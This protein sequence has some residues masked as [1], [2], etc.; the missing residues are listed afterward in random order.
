[1][2]RAD[3]QVT[4]LSAIRAILQSE[5][6]LHLGMCDGEQPY[7]VPMDYGYELTD[8]G[9]LTL[10]LH[11]ADEGK[12]LDLLRANP[13]VCFEISHVGSIVTGKTTSGWTAKY[14]SIIGHGTAVI[15]TDS[16]DKS[17]SLLAILRH[18]GYTGCADFDPAMLK[19]TLTLCIHVQDYTAKSN[20]LP[21][22]EGSAQ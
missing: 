2:R 12:K 14:R 7:I 5:M 21:G 4:D 1:M 11:C 20:I 10:Y 17:R 18:A 19:R 6:H 9:V 8:S 16:A 3:R 13:R 22:E 15:E